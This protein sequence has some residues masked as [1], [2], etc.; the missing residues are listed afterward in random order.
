MLRRALATFGDGMSAEEELRW[1]WLASVAA[2]RVWDDDGWGA[3]SARHVRLAR[4]AGALSELPLALTSHACMLLFAGDLTAAASLTGEAQVVKEATGSNL[5]PYGALGLAAL[6][7][8]EAGTLAMLEATKEDVTRRGEGAGITFAEWANAVLNNGLGRYPDA[9]VAA[10]RATSYE[11]DLGSM[12]WPLVELIEAAARS[13]VT[14]T[15]AA[16]CE[17]FAVMTDASG[18]DWALGVQARSRALLSEGEDAE[19]RYREA[20]ER[21]GRTRMRVEFARARLVYGEWL[22]RERRRLEARAQ[23]RGAYQLLSAMGIEGSRS[24]PGGSCGPPGRPPAGGPWSP[25]GRA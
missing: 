9:L 16:A 21:L 5:A 13:G 17:R 14:E 10:R 15:A 8:D 25:G 12:I 19:R 6:R 23:L 3:L 20:I 18:T 4:R 24:G 2:M 1:L 7:G 11:A 22:R